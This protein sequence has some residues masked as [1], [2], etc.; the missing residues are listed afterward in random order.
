MNIHKNQLCDFIKLPLDQ[1]INSHQLVPFKQMKK[2]NTASSTRG[3]ENANDYCWT[4]YDALIL[5]ESP[6]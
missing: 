4:K 5:N 3:D 2:Q 6:I 1:Q